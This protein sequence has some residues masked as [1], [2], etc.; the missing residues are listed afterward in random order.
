MTNEGGVVTAKKQPLLPRWLKIVLILVGTLLF[1]AASAWVLLD[2]VTRQ[3]LRAAL[4]ETRALGWP[5]EIDELYPEPIPDEENAAL[6]YQQAFGQ[7]ALTN[8]EDERICD[9]D[10]LE[11]WSAL[12]EEEQDTVRQALKKNAN[13]LMLLHQAARLEKCQFDLR[14]SDGF[15]MLLPHLT[16]MRQAVRVLRAAALVA[17]AEGDTEQA[18]QHW[19]DSVALARDAGDEKIL[20]SELVRLACFSMSTHTLESM[21]ESGQLTDSQLAQAASALEDLDLR[22][23]L[24]DSLRGELAFARSIFAGP[25]TGLEEVLRYS[26]PGYPLRLLS[27]LYC[28]PLARPWR[29][30]DRATHLMLMREGIELAEQPYAASASRRRQWEQKVPP[31]PHWRAPLTARLLPALTRASQAAAGGEAR[32]D[33]AQTALALERYRLA[34]GQYPESLDALVP[35][36]LPEVPLDPFDGKPLRYVR[37]DERVAVYSVGTNLQDDGGDDQPSYGVTPDIVFTLR[38]APEQGGEKGPPP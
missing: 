2:I 10:S 37:S 8:D 30:H 27:R 32:R 24:A 1:L 34:H 13:Y 4:A 15:A 16:E 7:L 33:L 12:T 35:D 9:V 23:G 21:V 29:Q 19:L 6:L 22:P 17:L 20:I 28:S 38:R 36:I 14:Y 26:G 31:T 18:C 3:D 25:A 11:T 5:T